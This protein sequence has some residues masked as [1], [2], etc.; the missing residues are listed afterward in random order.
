M[1]K[2]TIIIIIYNNNNNYY[3]GISCILPLDEENEEYVETAVL[4]SFGWLH[5]IAPAN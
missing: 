1:K 5:Q 3:T 4:L 2:I